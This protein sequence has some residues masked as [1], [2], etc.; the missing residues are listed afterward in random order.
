MIFCLTTWKHSFL[1]NMSYISVSLS[2]S[3]SSISI[4][5]YILIATDTAYFLTHLNELR[6]TMRLTYFSSTTKH[7]Y[8]LAI[9][10]LD[11]ERFLSLYAVA[12]FPEHQKC[13]SEM[14]RTRQNNDLY[15]YYKYIYLWRMDFIFHFD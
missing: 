15:L 7:E 5:M 1:I 14:S 3:I 2:I 9:R 11:Q 10:I 8:S 13:V 6:T 12:L 4:Y